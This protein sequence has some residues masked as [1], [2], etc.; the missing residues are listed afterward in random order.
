MYT[1]SPGFVVLLQRDCGVGCLFNP[2]Q[3]TKARPWSVI[4]SSP[5]QLSASIPS[6]TII[7]QPIDFPNWTSLHLLILH[8][9]LHVRL[10]LT[11]HLHI[12]EVALA[13]VHPYIPFP[14]QSRTPP[15]SRHGRPAQDGAPRGE[16]RSRGPLRQHGE[17][18]DAHQE[19]PRLGQSTGCERKGSPRSHQPN[20]RQYAKIANRKRECRPH[21]RGH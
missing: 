14:R 12:I 1:V 17:N 9:V 21:N 4:A 8:V 7:H 19:D 3:I 15:S 18:E 10:I 20:L 11:H 5:R 2:R 16:R 6:H 13:A